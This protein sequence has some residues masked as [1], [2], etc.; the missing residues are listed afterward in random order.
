MIGDK[1]VAASIHSRCAVR[2]MQAGILIVSVVTFCSRGTCEG[3][4]CSSHKRYLVAD[5]LFSAMQ[6]LDGA[7]S[8]VYKYAHIDPILT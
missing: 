6:K 7:F 4:L 3:Y 2:R 8:Q 1:E 5:G